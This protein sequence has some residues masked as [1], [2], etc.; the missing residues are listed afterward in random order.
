MGI[1]SSLARSF[2]KSNKLQKLQKEISPPRQSVEDWVDLTRP[3]GISRREQALEEFL[4][5]CESDEGVANVIKQYNLNRG[6]LKKNI[7]KS[8]C[9]WARSIH[10]R[11]LCSAF[12][13]RLLRTIAV[14]R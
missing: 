14:H 13:H 12:K 4:D 3:G 1:F 11:S 7:H 10:Q 5:L 8:S 2:K 9:G 6:D